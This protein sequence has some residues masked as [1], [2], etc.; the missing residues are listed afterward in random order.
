M[1]TQTNTTES[2]EDQLG[3]IER[4]LRGEAQTVPDDASFT[5]KEA[6][7]FFVTSENPHWMEPEEL[8]RAED[9]LDKHSMSA[10]K[11]AE[12]CKDETSRFPYR[13]KVGQSAIVPAV[14]IKEYKRRL[15]ADQVKARH[16]VE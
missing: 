5:Y 7:I 11:M 3:R 10:R 16:R 1:A 6:A 14:A 8:T 13:V 4:M 9:L 12:L 2:L 15:K